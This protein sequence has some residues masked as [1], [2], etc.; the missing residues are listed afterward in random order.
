MTFKEYE[1]D[2]QNCFHKAIEIIMAAFSNT[3]IGENITRQHLLTLTSGA[4]RVTSRF[5]TL[6]LRGGFI[7][8][9]VR[10]IYTVIEKLPSDSTFQNII[11]RAYPEQEHIEH[12]HPQHRGWYHGRNYNI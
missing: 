1:Q 4:K 6:L 11:F 8:V 10:G 9:D 12:L 2:L 5:R 7:R 3:P